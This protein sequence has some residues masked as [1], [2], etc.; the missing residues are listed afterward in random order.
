MLVDGLPLVADLAK[1]RDSY[2]A[3]AREGRRFLDFFG[4]FG[5]QPLGYNHPR[6]AEAAFVNRLGRAAIHKPSNSDIYTVELAEFVQAFSRVG[7]PEELPHLFLV[8]GGSLAVENAMKVA[9][10]WKVRRNLAKGVSEEKG[11]QVLHF[12]HAFHGRSGYTMSV[13]NTDPKKVRYFPKFDWPRCSS[14]TV[15][16]PLEGK[17]LADTEDD[18]VRALA[19]VRQVFRDRPDEIACILIEPIQCEGGDRHLR[20]EFLAGLREIADEMEALLVFDEVQT[21]TAASGS[22]WCYQELGVV[23]DVLAFGK[24][25]QVCGVLAGP[26][27]DEVEDNVF[28]VSSRIN[29]TWGGNLVDMVRATRVLEVIE[30][31]GLAAH[32]KAMGKA[33]VDGLRRVAEHD[34]RV[35]NVRGRGLLVAFDL[36]SADLRDRVIATAREKGF[37]CLPAGPRSIR[38]RPSLSVS[39]A[40]VEH[41]LELT[42]AALE[43]TR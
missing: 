4:F 34:E 26:R 21:G 37:L 25:M 42:M 7:I 27:I 11:R 24:K 15:R 36:P 14:P 10:D 8:S 18:E 31:D 29:S 43:T 38:Y 12:R 3:D 5:S 13:T 20:S 35:T 1:S 22:F 17:N 28:H 9:F 6:L 39:K 40:E 16:F 19:E 23:P 33:L 41:A 2:L 30:S 32:A